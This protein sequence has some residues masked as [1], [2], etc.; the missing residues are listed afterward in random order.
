MMSINITIR[1]IEIYLDSN[2]MLSAVVKL[3]QVT[4]VNYCTSLRCFCNEMVKYTS[5]SFFFLCDKIF[6][7]P[8]AKEVFSILVY[9]SN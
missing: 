7:L 6:S 4:F 2:S 8:R 3:A 1:D 5:V 9:S